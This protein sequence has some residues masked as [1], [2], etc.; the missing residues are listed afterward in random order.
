MRSST[1][2]AQLMLRARRSRSGVI[3]AGGR[4]FASSGA[5]SGGNTNAI[6]G[7]GCCDSDDRLGVGFGAGAGGFVRR[8]GDCVRR[9]IGFARRASLFFSRAGTFPR[10]PVPS[11][12]RPCRSGGSSAVGRGAG[13]GSGSVGTAETGSG[14]AVTGSGGSAVT[15]CAVIS[16][17]L[18]PERDALTGSNAPAEASLVPARGREGARDGSLARTVA[19]DG[20][21]PLLVP[22]TRR[23][24]DVGPSARSGAS[25]RGASSCSDASLLTASSATRMRCT[26]SSGSA[27]GPTG[28][29]PCP[30]PGAC[31]LL[32]GT[33][34]GR[35]AGLSSATGRPP[36][37]VEN[38]ASLAD[39]R[40]T[41]RATNQPEG[42]VVIRQLP[43]ACVPA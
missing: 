10:W 23:G 19:I 36:G 41:Q 16:S 27:A 28:L 5:G 6:C 30:L 20:S 14:W 7:V 3:G 26:T 15:G 2:M 33:R 29:V 17:V 34:R 12:G 37:R 43:D 24:R 18:S 1:K 38:G 40:S 13:A 31:R 39:K 32:P 9:V 4:I 11:S 35:G 25:G 8:A 22:G 21:G 42:R